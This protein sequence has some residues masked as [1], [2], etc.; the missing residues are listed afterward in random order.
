MAKSTLLF[1]DHWVLPPPWLRDGVKYYGAYPKGF[2]EKA[3]F[4]LGIGWDDA[5]LHV[6]SG[7]V[8]D[9]WNP[10]AIGENDFT[11]DCNA[12][13][14]PN[15]LCDVTTADDSTAMGELWDA[16]LADPP[17]TPEDAKH[18][19]DY[20]FPNPHKLVKKCVEAVKP[21]GR[22]GILH[23]VV[24]R[25]PANARFRALIGVTVGSGTRARVFSIF[26]KDR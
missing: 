23:L 21:G 1:R 12:G 13:T 20:P 4:L 3:R 14:S 18:Y 26:E 8:R 2:L 24:P 25:C 22:V 10:K 19:G 7:R 16:I 9:Y 17:Y 11:L 6:C 15:Y 5:L